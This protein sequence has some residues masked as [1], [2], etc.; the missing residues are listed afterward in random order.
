MVDLEVIYNM[1]MNCSNPEGSIE[2]SVE[3]PEKL[4]PFVVSFSSRGP[5]PITKDIL[6]VYIPMIPLFY[7][8]K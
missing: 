8:I 7:I 3:V 6:K 2:K 5:N 4:A 1:V